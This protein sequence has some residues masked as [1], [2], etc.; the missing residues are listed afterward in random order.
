[1]KSESG[2][3]KLEE[4]LIREGQAETPDF[5]KMRQL[6]A[7]GA[8]VHA[9]S[10]IDPQENIL[11]TIILGYPDEWSSEVCDGC[12]KASCE[13]C[14]ENTHP[15]RDMDGRH[16]PEICRFFLQNGFDVRRNQGAFGG[17]CMLNLTWSSYDPYILDV[18]KLLLHAGADPDYK[19]ED[20]SLRNWVGTK[21]SAAE[22]VDQDHEL[23]N[24]FEAMYRILQNAS[25][26]RDY[27][28][29]EYFAA[30]IGKTVDRIELYPTPGREPIFTV[31]EPLCYSDRCV[32]GDLVFWCGDKALRITPWLEIMVDP[33]VAAD[34]ARTAFDMRPYLGDCLGQSLT[35]V[36]FSHDEEVRSKCFFDSEVVEL[37]FSNGAC[38]RVST[39]HGKVPPEQYAASFAVSPAED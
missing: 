35:K 13:G 7:A 8:D 28:A 17:Q 2:F 6:L 9:V 31:D 3:G 21:C 25:E 27:D 32:H 34:A 23:E 16:L 26:G 14:P 18:L 20:G 22:C 33:T 10:T 30:A 36:V 39:N 12:T 15:W 11:S 24:L 29:V 38:V 5:E 1:M 4:Q 37:H 19:D